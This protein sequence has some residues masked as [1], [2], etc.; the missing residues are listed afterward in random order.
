MSTTLLDDDGGSI[1]QTGDIKLE[2][3]FIGELNVKYFGAK[4][5]GLHD[6]TSALQQTIDYA[7]INSEDTVAISPKGFANGFNIQIPR[8]R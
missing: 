8:G 4:G 7:P 5:D 1:I 2:H 6:D 3:Q